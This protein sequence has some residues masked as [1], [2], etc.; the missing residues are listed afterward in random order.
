MTQHAAL[1]V[2]QTP[3]RDTVVIVGGKGGL[4][5]R[6]RQAVEMN[7]YECRCYEDRVPTK[8]GPS[9]SKIALVIVLVSMVSHSLLAHAR[10]L[11]GDQSRIV[12]LRSASITSIRQTVE[13][14]SRA[15]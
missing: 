4:L 11:A 9:R 14:A 8:S 1:N 3:V 10:E 12:Y 7:G 2:T 13:A 5:A 6:Y 15:V